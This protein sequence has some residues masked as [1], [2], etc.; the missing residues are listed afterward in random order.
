MAVKFNVDTSQIQRAERLLDNL[1]AVRKVKV[2]VEQDVQQR[3]LP[4]AGGGAG[5]GPAIAGL[6]PAA[7]SVGA[8]AAI[9][10]ALEAATQKGG[11]LVATVKQV[12][13]SFQ[14]VVALAQRQIVL[15][16]AAAEAEE[17]IKGVLFDRERQ[18]EKI[19][20]KRKEIGEKAAGRG[21]KRSV[22]QL[23]SDLK[24]LENTL[25]RQKQTFEA[26][27]GEMVVY[28]RELKA[29]T[30]ALDRAEK[31]QEELNNAA[32]EFKRP[33]TAGPGGGGALPPGG[34][35]GRGRRGGGAAA[36]AA[37]G[38]LGGLRGNIATTVA[39]LVG[40]NEAI[41]E[42]GR[43]LNATLNRTSAEQRLRALSNGYDSFASTLDVASRA[44]ERFNISQTAA[45]QQIAQVYG[46]LRPL[47]LTLQ[48][49]ESIYT[50]FNTAA[51]LSGAN[52]AE[53]AGAFLQL[54]QALGA[55]ALRGEEFNSVAEQAPAVLTAIARVMD[56]P[57]GAL[58][59]LAKE[60]LITRDVVLQALK[61]IETQ[62]ASRLADVLDTPAA[63]LQKLN[64]R[65]D[66]L[67]VELGEL[68]LPAF[69]GLVEQLT[70]AIERATDKVQ[71]YQQGFAQLNTELN[72]VQRLFKDI[73]AIMPG[74]S[75]AVSQA[76]QD[77]LPFLNPFTQGLA[78]ADA[79]L[80]RMAG[81]RAEQVG[82]N[83]APGS[84]DA[85]QGADLNMAAIRQMS[86]LAELQNQITSPSPT[87]SSGRTAAEIL[88]EQLKTGE[89]L[90]REYTRRVQLL[91]AT[92]ELERE[93]LTIQFEEEDRANAIADAAERQRDAL[94]GL[95]ADI[96]ASEAGTAIGNS[97]AEGV[98]DELE[99]IEE[100]KDG[101][102]SFVEDLAAAY[103]PPEDL[104][105][106]ALEDSAQVAA[107]AIEN[108]IGTAIEGLITGADD[109]NEK[110]QAIASTLLQD[111][112]RLFLRAG[113][114]AAAGP[115]GLFGPQGLPGFANGG[116]IPMG[117]TAVVGERGPEI[118]HTRP[119][120]TEVISNDE[121]FGDAANA[122][123]DPG[124]STAFAD[125]DEAMQMASAAFAEANTA[126]ESATTTRMA[127]VTT[128]QE[129]QALAAAADPGA[130]TTRI[131][132][133]TQVINTVE[134][135]TMDQVVKVGQQSAKQA[136]ADVFKDLKNMPAARGRAGVR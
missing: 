66:D 21:G 24:T 54:S 23:E 133:D 109:L 88:A 127:N 129:Q 8:V 29:V 53:S 13:S 27:S 31:Q 68:G 100:L 134:Y 81:R 86:E 85:T 52:A 5:V 2:V 74:W 63:K 92:T 65:L 6:L 79:A 19:A 89:D 124:T 45:E 44:A 87:K 11:A 57:V 77:V 122:L 78:M 113:I 39:S 69:I 116:T 131:A 108:T 26:V 104:F 17:K 51:R 110:L 32:R 83:A 25:T 15:T 96:A 14:D 93:L 130:T 7:A 106:K 71:V 117:T 80:Q 30:T 9:P 94:R 105:G 126:M 40:L 135:A 47:G 42:T 112:G 107:S 3:A 4:P 48:E 98:L 91:N 49:V 97:L 120:G 125:A 18:L 56:K 72:K 41:Q 22:K 82:E 33:N 136:R 50:G 10:K 103:E 75:N 12:E 67:R 35:G 28:T 111:L 132:L 128:R 118:V 114:N 38:A 123:S 90:S 61:D 34:G 76:I 101:I 59:G 70:G 16:Q 95:S 58:K 73:Q 84:Y 46:R 60:G 1:T 64:A 37:G 115:G 43:I 102:K 55:G 121:A 62:G 99:R 20:N 36:A 119:G